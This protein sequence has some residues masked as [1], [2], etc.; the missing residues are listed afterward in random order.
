MEEYLAGDPVAAVW[1]GAPIECFSAIAR[2]E[3]AGLIDAEDIARGEAKLTT[4]ADRWVEVPPTEHVRQR[5]CSLL[6]LHDIRA[7]DALQLASASTARDRGG[8]LPFV[9]LDEGLANAARRE[10]FPV[11]P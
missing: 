11:F 4:M 1:W 6:R 9:T 7:G 5:G 3:R 2:R 8:N 10:G